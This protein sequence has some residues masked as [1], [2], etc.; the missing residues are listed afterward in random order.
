M[1]MMIIIINPTQIK[2]NLLGISI[3]WVDDHDHSLSPETRAIEKMSLLKRNVRSVRTRIR[4]IRKLHR[5]HRVKKYHF[6]YLR[7]IAIYTYVCICRWKM[8]FLQIFVASF[9]NWKARV[10]DQLFSLFVLAR[11]LCSY[12]SSITGAHSVKSY[13]GWDTK[14]P[15]GVR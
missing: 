10:I 3:A 13:F 9:L 5:S 2:S 14:R 4:T 7:G 12:R 11:T 1:M 15:G 6:K 8:Q